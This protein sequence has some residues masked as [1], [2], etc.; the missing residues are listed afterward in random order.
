[1]G[2]E[3]DHRTL[4]R[5]ICGEIPPQN[6]G[7][8]AAVTG[9]QGI[10]EPA[11]PPNNN[12]YERTQKWNSIDQAVAALLPFVDKTAAASHGFDTSKVFESQ[13]F[14]PVP[15]SPLG[16]SLDFTVSPTSQNCCPTDDHGP[17]RA[18][19]LRNVLPIRFLV[20]CRKA[21]RNSTSSSKKSG[22]TVRP[23]ARAAGKTSTAIVA[24]TARC[25]GV[26]SGLWPPLA[27]WY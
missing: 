27:P 1:M 21:V 4:A 10:P 24:A 26:S 8:L 18:G 7:P 23:L 5:V 17:A 25:L 19:P 2:I 13:P 3:S 15:P 20:Y 11:N 9:L 22:S 16:D 14:T 12:E 6:G